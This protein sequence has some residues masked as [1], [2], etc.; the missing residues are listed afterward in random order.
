MAKKEETVKVTI[1]NNSASTYQVTE[2]EKDKNGRPIV[3]SIPPKTAIAL[4]KKEAERLL[5]NYP[6]DFIE[7]GSVKDQA[8]SIKEKDQRIVEL[9]AKEKA[10]DELQDRINELTEIELEGTKEVN[11]LNDK[12]EELQGQ[13]EISEEAKEKAEKEVKDL[14]DLI[15]SAKTQT[16]DNK[17][18]N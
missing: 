4:S 17:A 6:K 10:T 14:N 11:N 2:G 9:E 18:G 8:K 15:D 16:T 1:Y 5:A 3:I 7:G 12:I 13:L